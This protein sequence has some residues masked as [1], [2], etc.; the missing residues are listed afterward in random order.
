MKQ[1]DPF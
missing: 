1:T